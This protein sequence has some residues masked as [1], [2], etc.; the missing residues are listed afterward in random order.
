MNITLISPG[1]IPSNEIIR[2]YGRNMFNIIS[3]YQK[4]FA[5]WLNQLHPL[6]FVQSSICSPSLSTF[7][8]IGLSNMTHSVMVHHREGN[9]F[10]CLL[11]FLLTY[12]NVWA[13]FLPMFSLSCL[14]IEIQEFLICCRYKSFVRS[15]HS[16][17]MD[18]LFTFCF[19]IINVFIFDEI[20][21]KLF[22]II[23]SVYYALKKSLP[24]LRS[25]NYFGVCSR[26]FIMLALTFTF[27]IHLGLIFVYIGDQCEGSFFSHMKYPVTATPLYWKFFSS[28]WNCLGALCQKS[29]ICLG[30]FLK[31]QFCSMNLFVYYSASTPLW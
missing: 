15:M 12:K 23:V 14:F 8:T 4:S 26:T 9:H 1:H 13:K 11:H 16:Q 20:L 27:T 25:W 24:S 17:L 31:S 29:Y 21:F 3:H 5:K 28:L 7:S 2:S 19:L 22:S 6:L 10:K 18:G 30:L